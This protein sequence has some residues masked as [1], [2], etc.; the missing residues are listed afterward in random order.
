MDEDEGLLEDALHPLGIRHEVGGEVA[1]V[2]LHPLDDLDGGLGALGLLDGD[3]PLATHLLDRVA[4]ELA[5]G[6]GLP[7]IPRILEAP[8]RLRIRGLAQ[9]FAQ[10]MPKPGAF[11]TS[12]RRIKALVPIPLSHAPVTNI[13]A[14]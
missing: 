6:V 1:P 12:P 10:P 11:Q 14:R 13:V 4:D 9:N 8:R 5:R 2:E 3:D 7:R